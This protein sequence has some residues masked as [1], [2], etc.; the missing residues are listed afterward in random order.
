M[1]NFLIYTD[2]A[3]SSKRNQ[4]G[5]G[6]IILREDE[7]VQC[8]SKAYKNTTNNRMELRAVLVALQA[9][10]KQID[11]LT[12]YSDSMYVIGCAT[13]GWKRSKNAD[14]WKQ[15]DSIFEETQSLVN[16]PIKFIHVKGHDGNKFNEMCD[17]LAVKASQ[18]ES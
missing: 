3:Y 10:K 18:Y 11:S 6:I 15:Y 12:I 8:Y 9:I 14:L 5:I 1:N 7:L 13:M 2:G 17:N 4:G 16:T